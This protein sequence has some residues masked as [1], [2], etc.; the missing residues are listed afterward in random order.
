[1]SAEPYL[2]RL[3]LRKVIGLSGENVEQERNPLSLLRTLPARRLEIIA[4]KMSLPDFFD[5]NNVGGDSHLQFMNW[6][7]DNN[8]AWDYAADTRGYTYAVVLQYYDHDFSARFAEALEPTMAN[9][10]TLEWNP[11]DAHAENY[12]LEY[13]SHLIPKMFGAIRLWPIPTTQ[14]WATTTMRSTS[15]RTRRQ[16][17]STSRISLTTPA[18]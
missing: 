2:A 10:D 7:V 9:G 1:M 3:W 4:G 17:H 15:S 12:E 16:R 6:T 18:S 11:Q 14:T 13:D 5:I 8:G